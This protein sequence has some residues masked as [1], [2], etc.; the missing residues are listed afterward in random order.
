MR[1]AGVLLH[2]SSLPGRFGIGTLGE[3]ARNFVDFL[4]AA[5]FTAW[6]V[7]PITP[8]GAS[9]SPYQSPSSFRGNSLFIDPDILVEK[10]LLRENELPPVSTLNYVDY[11]TVVAHNERILSIAATRSGEDDFIECEFSRQWDDLLNYAHSK[12]IE[13]IGD[14]PIYV[15]PDSDGYNMH[16]ELFLEDAVAGCPPDNFS[17]TGQCWNNPLYDWD[18]LKKT[19]YDFWIKRMESTFKRFDRVRLDHFRGFAGYW[20][21]PKDAPDASYGEWRKGPGIELF[22]AL[23]KKLG[24]LNLIAEDLGTITEDVNE[25]RRALKIP[26][27]AVLQFA[28]YDANNPYLPENIKEDCV[29]YTGTHDNNTT[30]GWIQEGG[31]HVDTARFLLGANSDDEL[32]DAMINACLN[33]KAELAVLPIQDILR[34]GKLARMNVPGVAEGNWIYRLNGDLLTPWLAEEYRNRLAAANRI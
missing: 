29:C 14:L 23:E 1:K 19:G 30:L 9:Y 6:Q 5:G 16:P 21:I 13:I 3:C 10:G 32:L 33:S 17:A 8:V 31:W 26:G 12:G 7:L 11:P 25:L 15:A 28:F 24:K 34:Q 27:M 4:S 2:I 22:E 18:A 20:A